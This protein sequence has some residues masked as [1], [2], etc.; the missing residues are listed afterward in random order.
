MIAARVAR[1]PVPA[2][3]NHTVMRWI[4]IAL[5]VA[6]G[7]K[8]VGPS[9]APKPGTGNPMPSGISAGNRCEPE[10]CKGKDRPQAEACPDNKPRAPEVCET[11][12]SNECQWRPGACPS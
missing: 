12:V 9:V 3:S 11:D 1:Q 5:V 7:G 2:D 10:Q 4:A 6:C 8:D